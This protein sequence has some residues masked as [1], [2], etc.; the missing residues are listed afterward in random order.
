MAALNETLSFPSPLLGAYLSGN[1]PSAASVPVGTSAVT[2]DQGTKY[3]NGVGW[4]STPPN[5]YNPS[6]P[7]IMKMRALLAQAQL[8]YPNP[9]TAQ[10]LIQPSAHPGNAVAI[11]KGQSFSN[12]GNNY[13]CIVA[14]TTGTGTAP[15]ATTTGALVDGTAQWYYMGPTFTTSAL[16]PTFTN[17]AA[18][19]GA[20]EWTNTGG[21]RTD[22][23]TRIRDSSN[24][25]ITGSAFTDGG[26]GGAVQPITS[27]N[28]LLLSVAFMTDSATFQVVANG[29]VA[30][31][32]QFYV[33][34]VPLTLAYGSGAV[35]S[36]S[37]YFWNFVF[38]T[39]A[40]RLITM[41]LAAPLVFFGVITDATSKVW[42]PS[43]ANSFRITVTGSSFISGSNQHP[44][45]QSLSW[46]SL[47][48]KLLNCN[49]YWQDAA[50]SGTGYINSVLKFSV[51]A[52]FN[53]LVA[54]NPDMVIIAGGGINDAASAT[55]ATEQ[56]AVLAYLM[57]V[58]AALPIA[59]IMVIGSESGTT[60]PSAQIFVMEAAVAAAIALLNDPAIF[61]IPQC[62]TSAEKAWVSGTGTTAAPNT[63][64]N[65]D[66]Y[67]GADGTHP[68]QAG[69][70]YYAQQSANGI[71]NQV[72]GM[73]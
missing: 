55:L 53:P 41:E 68:V 3:S 42:A 4:Q 31:N 67:I 6:E 20:I 10:P 26:T 60:G 29:G 37:T 5:V 7:V 18:A 33:N 44:V 30:P 70:L 48:A 36:Q 57:Q 32:C 17:V 39:K 59:L 61:Y 9:A 14:G 65:T 38:A 12:S 52:R 62:S 50:G 16:A 1:L 25:L 23:A 21:T 22:A 69:C 2:I 43:Y 19:S 58:R 11:L 49:D 45:T 27:G 13:C 40:P 71:I 28:A 73:K 15:T 72:N 24:F 46:G 34:G 47:M 63:T 64:G 54:Y 51:P 66:I 56:A 8:G 35:Q